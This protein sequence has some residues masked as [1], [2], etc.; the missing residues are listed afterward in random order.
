MWRISAKSFTIAPFLKAIGVPA[1]SENISSLD[2]FAPG[3]IQFDPHFELVAEWRNPKKLSESRY[4]D[5]ILTK[6]F[7]VFILRR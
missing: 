1:N 7:E 5:F 2:V 3:D 4:K 6:L